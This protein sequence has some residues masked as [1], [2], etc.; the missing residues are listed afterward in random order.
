VLNFLLLTTKV[1]VIGVT[2]IITILWASSLAFGVAM[3]H[4]EERNERKLD[5]ILWPVLAPAWVPIVMFRMVLRLTQDLRHNVH[6][7]TQR[8]RQI[9]QD[10]WRR[11][12]R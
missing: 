7:T 4:A 6:A 8:S 1:T 10:V 2:A 5:W 9:L 11:A 12:C 3:Y